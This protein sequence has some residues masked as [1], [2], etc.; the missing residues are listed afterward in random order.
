MIVAKKKFS[1]MFLQCGLLLFSVLRDVMQSLRYLGQWEGAGDTQPASRRGKSF[2]SIQVSSGMLSAVVLQSA[3]PTKAI[4]CLLCSVT[5]P[6]TSV[7]IFAFM[8]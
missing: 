3:I 2:V 8:K 1:G 6:Q 5:G 4:G 7:S